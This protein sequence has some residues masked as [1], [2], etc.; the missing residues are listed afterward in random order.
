MGP[1]RPEPVDLLDD[2]VSTQIRQPHGFDIRIERVPIA[3][4]QAGSQL[5]GAPFDS[6]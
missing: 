2:P 4:K 1:T 6:D 3:P 5:C